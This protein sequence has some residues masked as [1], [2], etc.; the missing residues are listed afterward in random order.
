MTDYQT[1]WE[2]YRLRRRWIIAFIV[3]EFLGFIL[4]IGIVGIES[5]K[6]F[7]RDFSLV[8]MILFMALYLHTGSRLRELRCPRC[9]QNYFGDFSALFGGLIAPRRRY[10]LFGKECAYCGLRKYSN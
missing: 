9:G 6:H 2:S 1:Q 10:S 7:G 5:T 8:A 4:F 3:I